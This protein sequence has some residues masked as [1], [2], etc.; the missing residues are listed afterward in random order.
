MLR[1]E[2]A[3]TQVGVVFYTIIVPT[4]ELHFHV[5]CNT[6]RLCKK[7]HFKCAPTTQITGSSISPSHIEFLYNCTIL[8]CI[9]KKFRGNLEKIF[10]EN[11]LKPGQA[12]VLHSRPHGI[13]TFNLQHH[14]SHRPP[15]LPQFDH[16]V[17]HCIESEAYQISPSTRF[18]YN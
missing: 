4:K 16:T 9:K 6:P 7:T 5:Q 2:V 13:S 3:S 14:I 15:H 18:S 17:K 12:P 10:C 8:C 11:R 1:V